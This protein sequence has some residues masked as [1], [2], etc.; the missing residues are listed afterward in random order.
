MQCVSNPR[1]YRRSPLFPADP[2]T[3]FGYAGTT[4]MAGWLALAVGVGF[5]LPLLRDRVAGFVIPVALATLYTAI[6]AVHWWSAEGG[7]DS[8]A[9]VTALFRSEWMLLAGWIHYLAYDLFIGA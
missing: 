5:R 7:F 8:L 4:A 2:D 6:V 1:Q 3:L 9:S